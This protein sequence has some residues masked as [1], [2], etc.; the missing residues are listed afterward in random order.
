MRRW[1]CV[2]MIA[3]CVLLTGCGSA[4]ET[5]TAEQLRRPYQTMDGCAMEA[6]VSCTQNDAVWEAEL[7]CDYRPGGDCTVE[8]LLPES[9]A[10]VKAIFTGS[11][12]LF[13]YEDI[14]LNAGALGSE[15]ISPAACLPRLMEALRDGW[16]LEE[17]EEE[18][19]DIP[20]LRLT[21]DQ[22][23][24]RGGKIL[25]TLWLRPDSGAPLRGEITVDDKI[26]LTAEF[27]SFEFYDK[28]TK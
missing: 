15:Q 24:S 14:T 3:L 5:I 22:S 12:W 4:E 19:N 28:I 18:W 20:C 16:L 27:T 26:I 21:V 17:N 1:M 11:D 13:E 9:I 10:G 6:K 25:S 8:V 2:P 7:R 23:G